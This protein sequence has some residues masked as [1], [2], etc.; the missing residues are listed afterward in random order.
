[1][2]GLVELVLEGLCPSFC[3]RKALQVFVLWSQFSKRLIWAF[4]LDRSHQRLKVTDTEQLCSRSVC[5]FLGRYTW[6][7]HF[8]GWKAPTY[9]PIPH[10]WKLGA[11]NPPGSEAWR[12]WGRWC[13]DPE[14]AWLSG[15][16]SERWCRWM[17]PGTPGSRCHASGTYGWAPP[18]G[19]KKSYFWVWSGSDKASRQLL[20]RI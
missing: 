12:W 5:W 16:R 13:S 20:I 18:I 14:G 15:T 7:I 19:G 6:T 17:S 8:S 3:P 11:W 4:S 10:L 2:C 9:S 1:M